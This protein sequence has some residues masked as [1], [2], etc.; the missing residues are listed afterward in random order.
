[1][2]ILIIILRLTH[3]LCGVFWA[4]ATMVMASH[5]TPAVKASGPEGQKFMQQFAGKSTLAMWL[6]VTG[7]LTL[8][9]G[10]ALFIINYDTFYSFATFQGRWLFGG[11][12][13]GTLAF[14]HGATAQRS[15]IMK[16]QKIG[17]EVAA[18][19]GPPT[20]EQGAQLGALSAKIARNGVLL[21]YLLAIT[22]V[23]MATFQ[24][25]V[26]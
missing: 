7:T 12:V 1:M 16:L 20:P 14:L 18:A 13:I 11:M 2:N 17:A 22:I 8:A 24:Y 3:I 5:V 6:T 9:A 21:A 15:A 25:M 4:G 26:F 10:I 19:G 23:V